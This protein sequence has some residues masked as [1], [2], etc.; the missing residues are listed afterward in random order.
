[1][2][3]FVK[4]L[5]VATILTL[6]GVSTSCKKKY[7]F[8]SK[9][10][11]TSTATSITVNATVKDPDNKINAK[12]VKA[13]II[14]VSSDNT[15]STKTTLSFTTLLT[16]NSKDEMIYSE[17]QTANK[18]EASTQYKVE[19]YAT[20][21]GEAYT[22]ATDS[23]STT[24]QGLNENDPI[25]VKTAADFKAMSNNLSAY[26]KLENDIDLGD[27]YTQSFTDT[28]PFN[29]TFDGNG[30]KIT[31]KTTE[32]QSYQG[33][34]GV[35]GKDGNVKNLTIYNSSI[36]MSRYNN[37]YIGLVAGLNKGK[38]SNC[39]VLNEG[40]NIPSE[41]I[42]V[43][44][45]STSS[46]NNAYVGALVGQNDVNASVV[47]SLVQAK[48]EITAQAKATTGGAI[49]DNKGFISNI[50]SKADLTYITNSTSTSVTA[51][52]YQIG[53]FVGNNEGRIDNCITEGNIDVTYQV[54]LTN[55]QR[56][57][58]LIESLGGF[59]GTLM[60]GSIT[61]SVSNSSLKLRNVGGTIMYVGAF[62]GNV[63]PDRTNDSALKNN[64][65]VA[66]NNKI[67]INLIS[68]DSE[69]KIK[70]KDG[71][72]IK[73]SDRI[74]KYGLINSANKT[75]VESFNNDNS[76][77][78]IGSY[79]YKIDEVNDNITSIPYICD[80]SLIFANGTSYNAGK[81]DTVIEYIQNILKD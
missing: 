37:M 40:E 66:Q 60:S 8:D 33:L 56:D 46:S 51:L 79:T 9:L 19:L 26:Y 2:K 18:L 77:Y 29:G 57:E 15:E 24:S 81:N 67:E 74:F 28:S 45:T 27:A 14:E 17:S 42:K 31:Y 62:V 43:T 47:D 13:R 70:V 22:L 4:C 64:V 69:W 36:T 68:K 61:N 59:A 78:I 73:E 12:S 3:R 23:I 39:K 41:N 44:S 6:V 54:S 35:V 80:D 7:N 55:T 75:S 30:H 65:V 38:I 16:K 76:I 20:V 10:A 1:M 48:I 72:E 21:D 25:S 50:T 52:T 53:G 58:S 32:A 11:L 71:E 63:R 5:A 34:F 49:G